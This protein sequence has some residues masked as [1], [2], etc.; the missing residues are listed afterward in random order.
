MEVRSIVAKIVNDQVNDIFNFRQQD[1]GYYLQLLT[2]GLQK[3]KPSVLEIFRVWDRKFYPNSEEGL[4]GSKQ[5][6][7]L[8]VNTSQLLLHGAVRGT[9]CAGS[10]TM[11]RSCQSVATIERV[12][13]SLE[14]FSMRRILEIEPSDKGGIPSTMSLRGEDTLESRC[15]VWLNLKLVTRSESEMRALRRISIHCKAQGAA[16][17]WRARE[18]HNQVPFWAVVDL[19]THNSTSLFNRPPPPSLAQTTASST[20]LLLAIRI[21]YLPFPLISKTPWSGSTCWMANNLLLLAV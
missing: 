4:A 7:R 2:E 19:V 9:M 5:L 17:Y 3:K 10:G 18:E 14:G 8:L 12:R 15:R 6:D 1:F 21:R 13:G 20:T 16:E 11:R